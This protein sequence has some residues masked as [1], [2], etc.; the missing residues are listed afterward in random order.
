MVTTPLIVQAKPLRWV[1][2]YNPSKRLG[3]LKRLGLTIQGL[4][5]TWVIIL[6]PYRASYKIQGLFIRWVVFLPWCQSL[7]MW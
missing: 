6:L 2:G 4:A 7:C 1:I 3:H 5:L